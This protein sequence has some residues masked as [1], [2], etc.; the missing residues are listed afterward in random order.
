V[1]QPREALE[2]QPFTVLYD[3]MDASSRAGAVARFRARF[4]HR[5]VDVQ[6][7]Q[8]V[9]FVNGREADLEV[10]NSFLTLPDGRTVLLGLFRNVTVC[11]QAGARLQQTNLRLEEANRQLT[12]AVAREREL[13]IAADA[14]SRA[15]SA[16]LAGMSH[17]LRTP[18][19]AING[20]AATL[21]ES[22]DAGPAAK[23]ILECGQD[24]HGIIEGVF[25]FS[26]L[27]SGQPLNS[28]PFDLLEVVAK[29]LRLAGVA[30]RAKALRFTWW[31]APA[32][33][34]TIT[35]DPER[36]QKKLQ[37]LL[38]NAEK[39]TARGR[40]HLNVTARR[41]AGVEWQLSFTVC[42][43]GIGIE[44]GFLPKL[45]TPFARE[46]KAQ[47]LSV[48][49]TGLG[50]TNAQAYARSMGGTLVVRSRPGLG[51]AFRCSIQVTSADSPPLL[52][53]SAPPAM[54]GRRLLLV[55]QQRQI[56]RMFS[57]LAGAWGMQVTR[58]A[59]GAPLSGRVGE[60]RPFDVVVVEAAALK[61]EN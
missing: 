31:I 6:Q 27:Q 19:N 53:S 7:E 56:G 42:D 30:A 20:A 50:L 2:G 49:G 17:E 48:G 13:A 18:L 39:F 37:N 10:S 15:K 32:T 58:V 8:R 45:F 52:P 22:P 28:R 44:P 26:V 12:A 40:I 54:S 1:G 33:P 51:S 47:A 16:F 59:A 3:Q 5:T 60:G 43:T 55:C 4:A 35:A 23:L 46:M 9:T 11:K 25:D 41:R 57:T 21:V 24:L 14:A 29:A 34:A 36:L 61:A 38:Q